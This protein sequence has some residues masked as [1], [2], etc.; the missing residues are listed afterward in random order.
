MTRAREPRAR[1]YRRGRPRRAPNLRA[2][3]RDLPAPARAARPA[4]RHAVRRRAADAGHRPRADGRAAAADPRRALARPLAAAGR[5]DVRADRTPQ[6]A[7]ASRSCWSSRTSC[8]RSRSRTRAY[9]L[10][11]GRFVLQGS[12][13]EL[14]QRPRTSSAPISGCDHDDELREHPAQLASPASRIVVAP[15]VYDALTALARRRRPASTRST[16]PARP[17]PTRGSAG[18]TSASSRMTE[19]ADTLALI[20]DRVDAQLIVDADTGY[21]NALNVA[22]H[23]ARCSSAPAPAAIQ[24]EDQ[25]LPKRCGHLARQGADPGRRDGGQDHGRGRRARLRARR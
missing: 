4:R 2:R 3:V 19:V 22:A 12:A 6:R 23:R 25:D 20:R 16:S 18:P 9:V 24:L 1:R 17:S 7:R 10:D 13:A 21:G 15:G 8:R 5:G 14:A 11:N